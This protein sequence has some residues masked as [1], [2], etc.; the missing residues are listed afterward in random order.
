MKLF[1]KKKSGERLALLRDLQSL[2]L[3]EKI[4]ISL[5]EFAK[6]KET[7]IFLI[8]FSYGKDSLC[9]K[10]LS[11]ESGI[12]ANFLYSETG[13]EVDKIKKL[14]FVE[15]RTHGKDVFEI[16]K[17]HNCY[18][19][20]SKMSS[21]KYKRKHPGINVSAGLCCYHIKEKPAIKHARD[22]KSDVIVWGNKAADSNRR[23]FH[24]IDYGFSHRSKN[25][26]LRGA[27]LY[28]LQHWL[29]S[30]VKKYLK[31]KGV[32]IKIDRLETGCRYCAT[33][34]TKNKNNLQSLLRSNKNDFDKLMLSGF[35]E[36]ICKIKSLDFLKIGQILKECPIILTKY[37]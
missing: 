10:H 22:I 37:R 35:G 12:N 14:D 16:W 30:D 36:Q 8:M 19:I 1:D 18:P 6:F 28:P 25:Q 9:I 4:K 27:A 34:F 31:K 32:N 15:H 3:S 5:S 29:D 24:F 21:P 33:D 23:K 26:R 17:D 13:L 11:E 20:F 7:D 2:P